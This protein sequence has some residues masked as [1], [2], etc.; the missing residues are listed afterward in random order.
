MKKL[1]YLSTCSTCQRIIK[2]LD[3]PSEVELR[4]I[5]QMPISEEEI[6]QMRERA[7][8]YEALF[9]RKA[10]KFRALGLHQQ[11]LSEADYRNWILKEYTFLKRPVLIWG[12]Q[13]FIGNQKGVVLAA[14]HAVHGK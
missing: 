7:G 9:S 2:M 12:D 14:V 3:L 13:I 8:S 1:F 6:E 10:L 4:D 11:T 5:K